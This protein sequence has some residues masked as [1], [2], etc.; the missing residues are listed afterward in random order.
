MVNRKRKKNI[1][2]SCHSDYYKST[3]PGATSGAGIAHHFGAHDFIWGSCSSIFSFLCS[4]LYIIVCPFVLFHLGTSLS[5]L[6]I[7]ASD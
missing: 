3:T 5:V 1:Y 2:I 4:V 7:T 6:I